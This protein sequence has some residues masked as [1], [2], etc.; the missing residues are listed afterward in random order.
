M[1]AVP[2]GIKAAAFVSDVVNDVAAPEIMHTDP[3]SAPILSTVNAK[4]NGVIANL[5]TPAKPRPRPAAKRSAPKKTPANTCGQTT[6]DGTPAK[7]ARKRSP[8]VR[9]AS[10]SSTSSQ[11]SANNPNFAVSTTPLSIFQTAF[12]TTVTQ[13]AAV[14]P[15][16]A[17]QLRGARTILPKPPGGQVPPVVRAVA[18]VVNATS[19]PQLSAPSVN[20]VPNSVLPNETIVNS[21]NLQTPMLLG[22]Q[23]LTF[24]GVQ[25]INPV[26]LAQQKMVSDKT[27]DVPQNST[28]QQTLVPQ[29]LRTPA[30]TVQVQLQTIQTP[31]GPMT[32][33]FLPNNVN[34][35]QSNISLA[36]SG[37]RLQFVSNNPVNNQLPTGF[38]ALPPNIAGLLASNTLQVPGF[39]PNDLSH[40]SNLMATTNT[41]ESSSVLQDDITTSEPPDKK[42]KMDSDFNL[43]EF[44]TLERPRVLDST[45]QSILEELVTGPMFQSPAVNSTSN[46]AVP[47]APAKKKRPSRPRKKKQE[48]DELKMKVE[49]ILKKCGEEMQKEVVPAPNATSFSDSLPPV[50]TPPLNVSSTVFSTVPVSTASRPVSAAIKPITTAAPIQSPVSIEPLVTRPVLTSKVLARAQPTL[51]SSLPL[52]PVPSKSVPTAPSR[53]AKKKTD[54]AVKDEKDVKMLEKLDLKL[55]FKGMTSSMNRLLPFHLLS[56]P[57][58]RP[59]VVERE[60]RTFDLVSDA[61]I[62]RGRH[63]Y[64]RFAQQMIFDAAQPISNTDI[65]SCVQTWLESEREEFE[66][67]KRAASEGLP[68]DPP[69]WVYTDFQHDPNVPYFD[70]HYLSTFSEDTVLP[71]EPASS[72]NS[73]LFSP[74]LTPEPPSDGSVSLKSEPPSSSSSVTVTSQPG[75]IKLL[76]KRQKETKPENVDR[77]VEPTKKISLKLR[78]SANQWTTVARAKQDLRES[79]PEFAEKGPTVG[80][81]VDSVTQNA[82]DSI[83]QLNKEDN[84]TVIIAHDETKTASNL[85][86]GSLVRQPVM[87]NGSAFADYFYGPTAFS[88]ETEDPGL[89]EAIQSIL[90]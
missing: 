56:A 42:Q 8:R 30:P 79:D 37:P 49:E 47:V 86:P 26:Q 54:L 34:I 33:A 78:M 3:S 5:K 76:I 66:A 6:T 23:A 20:N 83:L 64:A 58:I 29:P 68:V 25:L 38:N 18:P 40:Q 69:N 75:K 14:M 70:E 53:P 63:L 60:N 62:D 44:L 74:T 9:T 17:V 19:A 90:S 10:T 15:A 2:D 21:V 71:D 4:V 28:K 67:E 88:D 24:G 51:P 52:T 84:I 72:A 35:G 31:N 7:P 45:A 12:A 77:S 13:P 82:V 89:D 16:S 46:T 50:P 39:A 22:G 1:D 27:V 43:D 57:D 48:P 59:E 65:L 81:A 11:A 55:P 85:R 36:S 80:V 32:V 87:S 73:I 41:G 61:L